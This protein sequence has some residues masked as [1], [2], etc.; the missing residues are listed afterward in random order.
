MGVAPMAPTGPS[1]WT[2]LE[3]PYSIVSTYYVALA[4]GGGERELM[5]VAEVTGFDESE[6]A[7][8]DE[9]SAQALAWPVMRYITRERSYERMQV[10]R[11]GAVPMQVTW[12][13]I[14]IA[15]PSGVGQVAC[16][17]TRLRLAELEA[18]VAEQE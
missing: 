15:R 18:R 5:Y 17:R 16:Y 13:G 6:T 2:L 14:A 9:A 7:N 10:S 4:S 1:T 12:I 3:R 8:L 11:N